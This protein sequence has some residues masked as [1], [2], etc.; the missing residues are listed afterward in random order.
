MP[1]VKHRVAP[2]AGVAAMVALVSAAAA[3]GRQTTETGVIIDW[4]QPTTEVEVYETGG[5][6]GFVSDYLVRKESGTFVYS[7]RRPCTTAPCPPAID[8]AMGVLSRAA[9]DSL[10]AAVTRDTLGLH[11]ADFGTTRSAA[12]MIAYVV[13]LRSSGEVRTDAR[14][15]DGTMPPPMRRIVEAVHAA[16]SAAR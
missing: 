4:A 6:A 15:D 13:R 16:I 8:S 1:S 14:A 9:A 2:G 10:F 11:A 5:I 3:C 12:D 7:R